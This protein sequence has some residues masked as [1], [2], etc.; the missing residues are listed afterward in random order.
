MDKTFLFHKVF[1][2]KYFPSSSVFDAKSSK[3]SYAWQNILKARS[4]V[5]KGMIWRSS[6]NLAKS[7][8]PIPSSNFGLHNVSQI[9]Q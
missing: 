3:G 6:L 5:E 8:K 4:V 1:S 2:A 7:F 9:F